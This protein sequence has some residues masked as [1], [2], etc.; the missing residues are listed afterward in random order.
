M[1]RCTEQCGATATVVIAGIRKGPGSDVGALRP[2]H[3]TAGWWPVSR[4][5]AGHAP[6]HEQRAASARRY[7]SRRGRSSTMTTFSSDRKCL[8]FTNHALV[9][10]VI[11]A[12]PAV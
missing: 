4:G 12:N 7:A 11:A 1:G 3:H 8:L 2:L 10:G 6:P 5:E 9:L